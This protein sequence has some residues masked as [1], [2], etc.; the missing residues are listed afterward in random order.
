MEPHDVD[1]HQLCLEKICRI[2]AR[3]CYPSKKTKRVNKAQNCGNYANDILMIFG[4]SVAEDIA[5]KHPKTICAKCVEQI[6][7]YKKNPCGTAALQ[8]RITQR[9]IITFG[10]TQ[11]TFQ[12]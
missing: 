2:C 9:K 8:T 10:Q 7:Y 11:K 4:I 5:T 1:V 3:R 12:S 6:R